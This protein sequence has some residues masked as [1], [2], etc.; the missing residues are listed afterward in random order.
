MGVALG[1]VPFLL[2]R[3]GQERLG[4]LSLIW[5]VVGYFSFLDMGL[6]RAVTVAV[7]SSRSEGTSSQVH[8]L[9]VLATVSSLLVSLGSAIALLLGLSIITWGEPFHLSS[10]QLS[11]EVAQ[12]LLWMLPS[13]PLLLLSS[14]LRGHLEGTGAFRAL[15]LLRI[16]TGALLILGPCLTAIYTPDLSWACVSIGVVRLAQVVALLSLV[17]KAVDLSFG[18]FLTSLMRSHSAES[19]R[20]LLSFGGWMTLSNIVGPVIVYVDRFVISA[21]LSASAVALYAVPF[22]V[23]SRLPILITSLC[24]VL[25]PELARMSNYATMNQH[26][27]QVLRRLVSH[28]SGFSAGLMIAVLAPAWLL[29]PW[30][31]RVWMGPEFSEQSTDVTQILLLAFGINAIAQIP[32]T[33]LQACGEA[34]SVAL[35]HAGELLPYGLVL[36]GSITYLGIEGAAWTWL[37]RGAVDYAVLAW[38]WARHTDRMSTGIKD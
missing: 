33:A 34:R 26:D 9:R 20:P 36:V 21:L 18:A 23:V 1:A 29:T 15:N 22:D 12:A 16:P 3:I 17:A 5:V 19:L 37:L 27:G 35:L 25:L 38:M 31:L 7:A 10:P 13:L 28:S 32:F 30:V 6:G 24:S 8:E 4:V 2:H 14:T 11:K